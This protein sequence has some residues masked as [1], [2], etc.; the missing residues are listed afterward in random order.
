MHEPAAQG[1]Q[2]KPQELPQQQEQ[3][4]Q[5]QQEPAKQEEQQA[6]QEQ[7]LD[8]GEDAFSGRTLDLSALPTLFSLL[9]DHPAE[10][11]WL[12]KKKAK[13]GSKLEL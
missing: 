10:N 12:P 1:G 6:P 4:A 5:Q 7:Q 3:P 2:E 13:G 8:L 11:S 9:V